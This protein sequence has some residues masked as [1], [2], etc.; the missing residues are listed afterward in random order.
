MWHLWLSADYLGRDF[1]IYLPPGGARSQ[2]EF[3]AYELCHSYQ[4][5]GAALRN[6]ATFE[7][8]KQAVEPYVRLIRAPLVSRGP[9]CPGK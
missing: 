6:A 1:Y 8:A 3:V 7:Q 5:I 9:R 4:S 2:L